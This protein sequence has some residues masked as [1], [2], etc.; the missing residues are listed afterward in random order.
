MPKL[1]ETYTITLAT[2]ENISVDGNTVTRRLD[3]TLFISETKLS[4]GVFFT[5]TETRRETFSDSLQKALK[6]FDG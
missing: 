2:T 4:Y 3:A 6:F 5:V 1:E